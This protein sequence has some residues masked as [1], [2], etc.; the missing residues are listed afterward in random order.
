MSPAHFRLKTS[1]VT[2]KMTRRTRSYDILSNVESNENEESSATSGV[3]ANP[4][5]KNRAA[6]AHARSGSCS[7][8]TKKQK[9]D[10][11]A[12]SAMPKKKP[13]MRRRR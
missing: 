8:S 2:K 1:S 10:M 5:G 11:T 12:T 6:H 9:G 13:N 4:S 7:G 3:V